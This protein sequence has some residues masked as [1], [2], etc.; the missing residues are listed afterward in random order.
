MNANVTAALQKLADA[1]DETIRGA[2][3]FANPMIL[4][5]LVYHATGDETVAVMETKGTVGAFGTTSFALVNPADIETIK[6]KGFELITAYRD[7][8]LSPPKDVSPE[9]LRRAMSLAA[10]QEVP[11]DELGLHEE[12]LAIDATP[13]G[14]GAGPSDRALEDFRV[15]VIG[16]GLAGVNAAI[17]L[18]AS[19]IPYKLFEKNAG[20]GG[21]WYENRYPGAR[22]DWPSRL[23][24]HSFGTNYPFTH[25]FAP[26][27]LNEAYVNWCVDAHDVRADICFET[28]VI[29]LTW[30]EDAGLWR[31]RTRHRDGTE[32]L[33]TANAIISAVGF[34]SRPTV[35]KFKGLE[36]FKGRAFHTARFDRSLDLSDKRVI[37]IG[38]GS[39]GMQIVPDLAPMVKHLTVFQRSAGWVFEVPGY[40]D[41]IPDEFRWL[42]S[43]VPYYTNWTRFGLAWTL[44][45][46]QLYKIWEVDPNWTEPNSVNELNYIFRG[47]M[48][49]Y[50]RRKLEGR[51]DLIAQ[52]VPDYPAMAKRPVSDNGWFDALRRENVELVTDGIDHFVADGIVT[53]SGRTVPADVVVFA[54]G[55]RANDFLWPMKIEGRNGVTLKDLWAKDGARAYWGI[56][57][58]GLPS[59]FMLYGPNA[60]PR[61]LGPVQYGE[62]AVSYFLQCFKAMIENGWTSIDIREDA[63]RDFNESLDVRTSVLVCMDP[64]QTSYYRN[65]FGRSAA[66][67][68]WS[69]AEIWRALAAPDFS[70]YDI[71]M[72]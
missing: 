4:R 25:W 14:W 24:S 30:D 2:L 60:N 5:G 13:R 51:P 28:E 43:H 36:T 19:G 67:S 45:D 54:T 3:N 66:Q 44:G 17:Q 57:V 58:P 26:Q 46:H 12:T 37:V 69:S 59:F 27:A 21:T 48:L 18:K 20:V 8:K 7:G 39:S 15:I 23:Y 56:T 42:E 61:N 47:Q 50:L 10:G 72:P 55:F 34:L 33:H 1:G 40:R 41:A 16:A 52:C 9:R 49:D 11:A 70:H 6:R 31:V 32:E 65:E 35:P 63:Y 68:P 29:A 64:R 62:W 38:T 71:V 22:V 53:K